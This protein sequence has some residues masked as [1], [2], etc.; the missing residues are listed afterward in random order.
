[1]IL[2]NHGLLTVGSSIAHAFILHRRLNEACELQLK[3][4]A[5][6]VELNNLS[7]EVCEHTAQQFEKNYSSGKNGNL[8]WEALLRLLDKVNPGYAE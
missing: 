7:P 1:M 2:R 6:G 3:A 8:Q 4:L 5:G